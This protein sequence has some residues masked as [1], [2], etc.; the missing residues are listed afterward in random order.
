[1]D[2]RAHGLYGSLYLNLSDAFREAL[3]RPFKVLVRLD[4]DA[5]VC[6]SNFE[7]KALEAFAADEHLGSLGS[8][9]VGYNREGERDRGWAKRQ[10]LRSLAVHA[11]TKPRQAFMIS[12][13]IFRA[14]K[15]GYKLG[16]G[17]M[18][19]A[20]IYRFEAL[21]E[22]E[23]ANLLGRVELAA[24][25]L[26]ED[27]IFGLCLF[28][29][30]WQLGEFGDRYDDLPMGVDWKGLPASPAELIERGKSIVHSTKSFETMDER[31]IRDEFR[32]ART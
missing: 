20:A 11:V 8:F 12:R 13:L 29:L 14:R 24:T 1:L 25:G 16:D 4:T 2:A 32:A 15:H 23:A 17:I 28:S 21:A 6:G 9:R 30:G 31:S 19:G 22:L 5:L 10:L 18:G 26:H 3:S 7:S 27:Y